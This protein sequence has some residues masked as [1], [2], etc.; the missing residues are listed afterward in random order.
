MLP[1]IVGQGKLLG[2]FAR[3]GQV[4]LGQFRQTP[5]APAGQERQ[6]FQPL[7][8]DERLPAAHSQVGVGIVRRGRETFL[9]LRH[10]FVGLAQFGQLTAAAPISVP[11]GR[12]FARRAIGAA[13]SSNSRS[14]TPYASASAA[15]SAS[16]IAV[17]ASS[18]AGACATAAALAASAS[19]SALSDYKIDLMGLC[20]LLD[21]L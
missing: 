7:T 13:T 11:S 15:S 6:P 18:L 4:A 2:Q 19:A 14:A 20:N 5:I 21:Q 3:V 10:R 8:L 12:S 1:P 17:W 9:G 16:A